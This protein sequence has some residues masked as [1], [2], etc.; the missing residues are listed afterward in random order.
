MSAAFDQFAEDAAELFGLNGHEAADL[1][2]SLEEQG[3]DYRDDELADW[4]PEAYDALGPL[5]DEM[6]DYPGYD[7]DEY[8]DAGETWEL[9]AESEEYFEQ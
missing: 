9:T 3:F 8:L 4:M 6:G 1:L 5:W 7:D 2:D